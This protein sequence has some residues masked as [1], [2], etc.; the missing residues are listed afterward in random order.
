MNVDHILVEMVEHA[1][2]K[3]MISHV[4]VDLDLKGNIVN[5]TL[6]NVNHTHARTV[7][8]V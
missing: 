6:M 2:T 3:L 1:V 5:I 4:D 8:I 7:V